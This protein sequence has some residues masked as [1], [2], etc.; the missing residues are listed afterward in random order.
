MFA[1]RYSID[2]LTL[3]NQLQTVWIIHA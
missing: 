2:C 1:N 3:L